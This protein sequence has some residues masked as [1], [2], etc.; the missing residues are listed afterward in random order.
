LNSK[1]FFADKNVFFL[2]IQEQH[3]KISHLIL[4]LF[5]V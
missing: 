1:L 3:F 2:Q 4:L 5:E